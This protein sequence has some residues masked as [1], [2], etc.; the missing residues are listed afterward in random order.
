MGIFVKIGLG[1]LALSCWFF[2][3]LGPFIECFKDH[4]LW[5]KIQ[6]W[7]HAIISYWKLVEEV[8]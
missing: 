6:D 5:T 3:F 2:F 7:W 8:G 4:I 1:L